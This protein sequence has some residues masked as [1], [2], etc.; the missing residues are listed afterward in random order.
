MSADIHIGDED[1]NFTYNYSPMLYG[2]GMPR[3]QIMKDAPAIMVGWMF[4]RVAEELRSNR[5]RY[6]QL[7]KGEGTWGTW[8]DCLEKLDR[9]VIVCQEN[10]FEPVRMWL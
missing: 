1:F 5:E 9:L 2:A 4:E 7:I 10:P 3:W 8:D 6:E